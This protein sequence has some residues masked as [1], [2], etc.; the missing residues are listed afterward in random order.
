MFLAVRCILVLHCW[1]SRALISA[2]P[3]PFAQR[4]RVE[5]SCKLW[6]WSSTPW[7][8]NKLQSSP[9]CRSLPFT[10]HSWLQV[11]KSHSE[12]VAEDG[13]SFK[14]YTCICSKMYSKVGTCTQKI[15]KVPSNFMIFMLDHHCHIVPKKLLGMDKASWMAWLSALA[16]EISSGSKGW[17]VRGASRNGGTMES[18]KWDLGHLQDGNHFSKICRYWIIMDNWARFFIEHFFSPY[19]SIF[20]LEELLILILSQNIPKLVAPNPSV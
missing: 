18:L 9:L 2:R 12:A 15:P 8:W 14:L 19:L 10:C 16:G 4:P 5:T 11:Q 17:K 13:S 6:P 20:N 7:P 1:G 3:K